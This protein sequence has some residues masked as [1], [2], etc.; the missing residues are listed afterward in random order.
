MKPA[1][2]EY[3]RAVDVQ[4]AIALL[5]QSD[6][7]GKLLAGGQSLT[8]MMNL[9]LAQPGLLVDIRR[10]D[11]LRRVERRGDHLYIGAAVTHAAIE[12]GEAPD[13]TKGM[14]AHVAHRI[15]YRAVRNRGTVGGS[16]AHFDPA[17]DWPTAL[18]A[19]GAE[20][21]V[22]GP[23]GERTVSVSELF[24]GP[25]MT[26]LELEE[27]LE[28]VRV[29]ALLGAA[30]WAY[31]KV[32]RK[33]GD[34]ATSIGAVVVDPERGVSRVVLGATDGVPIALPAVAEAL[35]SGDGARFAGRFSIDA[36]KQA[37]ADAGAAFEPYEFQVHATAIS[38]AVREAF[39][40]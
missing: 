20:V 36:A 4:N 17:G 1:K 24:M 32:W 35:G 13:V 12:D 25:Y 28:E 11:E 19:L 16:L 7:E 38:R 21:M 5:Q 2:F 10:L 6:G 14:M 37:L 26:V 18:T 39:S 31:Y 9:R 8:P 34:F 15:A 3:E 22:R 23:G 40:A 29:P 27:V 30:R 33:T